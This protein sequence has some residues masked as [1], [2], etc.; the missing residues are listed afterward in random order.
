M[1]AFG[2]VNG[3]HMLAVA[4]E[5]QLLLRAYLDGGSSHLLPF[6]SVQALAKRSDREK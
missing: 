2:I 6:I 1:N 3:T 5:S 4:A